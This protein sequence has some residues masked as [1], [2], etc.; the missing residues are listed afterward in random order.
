MIVYGRK[1]TLI[2]SELV[3]GQCPNC[4]ANYSVQMSVFQRYAHIF[5]IPCFPIGKTGISACGN[6]KQV[7]KLNQMPNDL[8]LSYDNLAS[9]A[10]SPIWTF[11]GLGIA[12]IIAASIAISDGRDTKLKNQYVLS[13]RKGDVLQVKEDTVYT[14]YKILDVSKDSV[15]FVANT[16]QTDLTGSISDIENRPYDTTEYVIPKSKLIEMNNNDRINEI[17]RR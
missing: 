7:L 9:Q 13:P 5:W 12:A 4:N 11:S 14:L 15:Y 17:L 6:C 2:K 1:S 10:K 16:Y 3:A 8:K